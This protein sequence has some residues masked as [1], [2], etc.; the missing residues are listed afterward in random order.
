LSATFRNPCQSGAFD[1]IHDRVADDGCLAWVK[2]VEAPNRTFELE[3]LV[4]WAFA[5]GYWPTA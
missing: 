4:R 1:P 2:E 5:N 3:K